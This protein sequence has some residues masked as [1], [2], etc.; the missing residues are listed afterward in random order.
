[1]THDITGGVSWSGGGG[2]GKE[3]K[4]CG[5]EWDCSVR[6]ALV[7]RVIAADT[8]PSPGKGTATVAVNVPEKQFPIFALGK[9]CFLPFL[10]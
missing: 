8:T 6:H 4:F 7:C 2:G 1:M 10:P 3:L 9:N 5:A